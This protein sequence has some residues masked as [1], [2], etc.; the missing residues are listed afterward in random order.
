MHATC[1]HHCLTKM[2]FMSSGAHMLARA[3][4]LCCLCRWL[5]DFRRPLALAPDTDRPAQRAADDHGY[6]E[7]TPALSSTGKDFKPSPLG[8]SVVTALEAQLE[9]VIAELLLCLV[10]W[11]QTR[12]S[13]VLASRPLRCLT[14]TSLLSCAHLRACMWCHR[15]CRLFN[16]LCVC[17]LPGPAHWAD[18]PIPPSHPAR[19][20]SAQG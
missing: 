12:Q 10:M 11:P 7:G 6:F 3:N 14:S 2:C 16:H 4:Y 13:A 5:T 15:S 19:E 8:R 9:K 20:R 17:R 18:R 1:V